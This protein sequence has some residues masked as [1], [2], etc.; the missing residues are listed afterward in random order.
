RYRSDVLMPAINDLGRIAIV[1]ADTINSQLG[2]GIDLNGEFGAS[3]FKDI[4]S[5]AAVALR[6]VA[7]QGN[8]GAGSLGV[9]IKDSSKLTNYDYKVTFSDPA[10]LNKVTVQRSDGKAM[11]TFDISAT[12][13]SVIDGFTLE[14][15]NGPMSA[16][17]SFKVS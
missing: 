10:N 7:G 1:T 14:L 3:M 11:G 12:P 16:G 6:S 2:Q 17:D 5:A 8:Q 13:P 9:T 15:K 4:N